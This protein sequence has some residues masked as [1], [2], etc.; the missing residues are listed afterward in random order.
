MKLRN[1]VMALFVCSASAL[2]GVVVA[3]SDAH[4]AGCSLFANAPV[5]SG[6]TMKATGGRSGCSN[7]VGSVAV[8]EYHQKK[9]LPDPRLASAKKSNV[10]SVKLDVTAHGQA[11][12]DVYTRVDSSTGAQTK[13]AWTRVH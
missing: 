8:A 9:Y 3:S 12:W 13:S 11:G 7:V 10:N 4:A 5:Q 2:A 1:N 6:T